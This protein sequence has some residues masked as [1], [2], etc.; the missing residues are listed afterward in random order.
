[1]HVQFNPK[2]ILSSAA[3]V[4]YDSI[5]QRS[6]FLCAQNRPPEQKSVPFRDH[7]EILCNPYPIFSQHFTIS[8]KEHMPQVILP[9]FAVY[10]ELTREL[11][12][13]VVFYNAPAC[14]ASAPDHMHFQAGNREMMPVE[15][16]LEALRNLYGKVL[17]RSG[18]SMITAIADG[19]RKFFLIESTSERFLEEVF[20]LLYDHIRGYQEAEPMINLLCYYSN[21]WQLLLFPREMHR[22]WQ[23]F[24]EGARNI[25]LSPAAVDMGGTL[26]I[27]LEKDFVSISK[28]D[29]EDIFSQVCCSGEHFRELTGIIETRL[30]PYES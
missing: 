7:Y 14:G 4:D 17:L 9:E 3:R 27:P 19:L 2:R 29:I 6:C 20:S 18:E 30:F 24:E 8:R 23:Y 13:L 12:D 26:I 25:L 10:L 5:L 22:P 16:E 11:H 28:S 21:G 15:R 1:V